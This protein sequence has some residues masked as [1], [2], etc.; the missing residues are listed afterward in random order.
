[1]RY[2]RDGLG[3]LTAALVSICTIALVAG[4]T[5]QQGESERNKEIVMAAVQAI[6]DGR[7]DDLDLYIAHNYVRHCQATPEANVTSLEEFKALMRFYEGAF[8]D[9]ELKIDMLVAE[10]DLVA[11]WGSYSGTHTGQ[12]GPYA[13]TGRHMVSDMGG[14]HRLADGKIVET[15]VTWDNLSMLDQLGLWSPPAPAT[16]EEQDSTSRR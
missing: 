6:T 10:G 14:V 15:W 12:M 1:M 11:I 2:R 3:K 16:A 9:T 8:T 5:C 7:Y 4:C 13:A